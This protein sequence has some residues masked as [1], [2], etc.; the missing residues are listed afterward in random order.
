MAQKLVS[1]TVFLAGLIAAILVSSVASAV[2]STQWAVGPQGPEGPQG[3]QGEQGIQGLTGDTGPTGPAGAAGETG[4]QGAKGDKGDTG[5]TGATGPQGPAGTATRYVIEGFFNVTQDGDLVHYAN[6]T[7]GDHYYYTEEH[8]KR[9]NVT[10][11]TLA[12]MP[13]VQVF[14][15][16]TFMST[17]N[18]TAPIEMWKWYGPVTGGPVHV[19]YNEGCVYLQYKNYDEY[20][21]TWAQKWANVT[22]YRFDGDYKIVVVK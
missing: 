20:F 16:T 7:D 14:V 1:M 22:Y 19:M 4:P 11:I 8:W 9:I 17:E 21:D 5:T 6:Q 10:Q 13:S 2:V 3:P 15:K 18:V 12:D